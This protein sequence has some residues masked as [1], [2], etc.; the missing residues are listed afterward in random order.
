MALVDY[1]W[2]LKQVWQA[3]ENVQERIR[4]LKRSGRVR[5]YIASVLALVSSVGVVYLLADGVGLVGSVLIF[6]ATLGTI[7]IVNQRDFAKIVADIRADSVQRLL[8]PGFEGLAISKTVREKIEQGLGRVGDGSLGQERIPVITICA[9][10]A[11]FP[12]YGSLQVDNSFTCP[13]K[14][15][16]TQDK[17]VRQVAE[18]IAER[19]RVFIRNSGMQ[20]VKC[21]D[22]I[23]LDG[24][25]L[26][27][28][29]QI[30]VHGE[31]DERF[32]P[33]WKNSAELTVIEG[34][35]VSTPPFRRYFAIQ[36]LFPRYLTIATLFTRPLPAGNAMGY[37]IAVSTLG[38]PFESRGQLLDRVSRYK[39]DKPHGNSDLTYTSITRLRRLRD[40]FIS[41]RKFKAESIDT[42]AI[43]KIGESVDVAERHAFEYDME[44]LA[45][46][47]FFWPGRF[48]HSLTWREACSSTF[49]SHFFGKSECL[50]CVR[51]LYTQTAKT[52]LD[53]LES[54]GYDVSDYR[55]ETGV[56]SIKAD[57]IDQLIVGEQ[58]HVPER[59]NKQNEANSGK[60]N[61]PAP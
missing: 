36:I 6:L 20:H 35:D 44:Q 12:G 11:P 21:G 4:A 10:G 51:A 19:I 29:S 32:P 47:S 17:S 59:V 57:K 49:T 9:D 22:L 34:P 16:E 46:E 53:G 25:S 48:T 31:N 40:Q 56:Y 15:G 3:V 14:A 5:Y 45:E 38:P 60:A 50:A 58:I 30:L 39:H 27:A 54:L 1:D 13:P 24:E 43:L 23:V 26:A 18:V 28:D 7:W 2:M 52:V 37:Q 61:T 33:L 55:S 8:S 41:N 42:D